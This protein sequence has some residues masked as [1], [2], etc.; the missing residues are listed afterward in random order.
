[1]PYLRD[2]SLY[3]G[4]AMRKK[5]G[6]IPAIMPLLKFRQICRKICFASNRRCEE[7]M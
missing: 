2:K 3:L 5:T 4:V 7:K 1:M 6:N